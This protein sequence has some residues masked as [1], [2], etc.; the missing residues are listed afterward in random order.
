MTKCVPFMVGR[1]RAVKGARITTR[2]K[3]SETS[4]SIMSV[5]VAAK[6]PLATPSSPLEAPVPPAFPAS[7]MSSKLN[8]CRGFRMLK[9]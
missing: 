7:M 3:K 5:E 8:A 1:P 9:K 2:T 4:P 6:L